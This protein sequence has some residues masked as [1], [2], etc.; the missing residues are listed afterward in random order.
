MLQEFKCL[1]KT[2]CQPV[3]F[4]NNRKMTHACICLSMLG[5]HTAMN[6]FSATLN[7]QN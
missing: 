3:E 1:P 2:S 7:Y 5:D 6:S 4:Y